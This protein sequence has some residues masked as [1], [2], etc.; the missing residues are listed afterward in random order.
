MRDRL[1][2]LG[3][4]TQGGLVLPDP[5]KLKIQQIGEFELPSTRDAI[6]RWIT[7]IWET[8]RSGRTREVA[9][10]HEDLRRITAVELNIMSCQL[11]HVVVNWMSPVDA[12]VRVREEPL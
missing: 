10:K 1:E 9:E 11:V 12:W 2:L 7:K 8:Q 6:L 5:L 4:F 3:H